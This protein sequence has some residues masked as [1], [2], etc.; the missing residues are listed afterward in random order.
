MILFP[1]IF[2]LTFVFLP[3]TPQHLL[4]CGKAKEAEK[5]LKFLRG[6]V[7]E[8]PEKVKNELLEMSKKIEEDSN[9]KAKSI[10]RELSEIT[11][12]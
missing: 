7:N 6:C 9:A 5:S 4:K 12:K 8:V 1:I 10:W 2:A 11:Q 3:E